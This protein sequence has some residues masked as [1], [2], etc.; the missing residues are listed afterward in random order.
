[1]ELTIDS[2][3]PIDKDTWFRKMKDTFICITPD[4]SPDGLKDVW[5]LKTFLF[6]FCILFIHF[7]KTEI[8][9]VFK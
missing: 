8:F 3:K 4:Y 1:M 6:I 7:S 5:Q 2:E 9:G